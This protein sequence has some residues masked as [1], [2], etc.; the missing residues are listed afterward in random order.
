MS[1]HSDKPG[2]GEGEFRPWERWILRLIMWLS[3]LTGLLAMVKG[4]FVDG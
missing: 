3:V 1:M 4:I 2:F